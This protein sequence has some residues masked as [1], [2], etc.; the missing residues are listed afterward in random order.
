[1]GLITG[2]DGK[3]AVLTDIQGMEDFL[4]DMDFKVAGTAD[5]VTGIQMDIKVKGITFEIMQKALEQANKARLFILDKMLEVMPEPREELS[6]YAPRIV[7]IQ[8]NPEKIG[9]LIG[10]GGKVI[11]KIQEECQVTIE[12]QDDGTVLVA[13]NNGANSEKAVNQIKSITMDLEVGQVYD[14]VVKR[15]IGI[16]AFV[17]VVPGKEGLVHI[18]QLAAER[19]EQVE[20]VVKVG[21][22]LTVKVVEIDSQGRVNLSHKATLPG[23]EDIQVPPRGERRPSGGGFNGD[24]RG[25]PG[26]RDRGG[27]DRG[28][29][30][31]DRP[32]Y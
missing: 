15:V 28:G 13:T 24:R 20:D 25:S 4:G 6:P 10:P 27:F 22:R 16:G 8:I 26:G 2:E 3:Y 12:V 32:R 7:K 31:R 30:P 23:Y 21:D 14:G 1:M 18:S 19:V 9:A 29:P 5:G 17:E 11:R